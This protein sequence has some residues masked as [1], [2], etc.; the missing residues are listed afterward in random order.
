MTFE[1]QYSFFT[2]WENG[3]MRGSV[4]S[5]GTECECLV[6][7]GTLLLTVNIS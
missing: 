4:T 6:D 1:H 7:L 3:E 5:L 2:K